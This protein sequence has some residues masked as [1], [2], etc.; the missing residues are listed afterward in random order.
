MPVGNRTKQT[1]L[2]KDLDPLTEDYIPERI[3]FRE[4]QINTINYYLSGLI[5]YGVLMNNILVYGN[6]GTGKTHSIKRVL[7]TVKPKP[8]VFYGMAYRS[9]SAHSFFRHFLKKNF[10]LT[11]HPRE[12]ISVYYSALFHLLSDQAMCL[13]FNKKSSRN[14]RF[15]A[16][17]VQFC[18]QNRLFNEEKGDRYFMI[19]DN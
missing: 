9:T 17:N 12:S 2:F 7:S 13:Y 1:Y 18:D 15:S 5:R 3:Q 16:L 8:N 6:P 19:L 4:K 14:T 10:Q 11:L